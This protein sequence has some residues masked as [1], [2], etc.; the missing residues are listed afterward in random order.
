M[1]PATHAHLTAA[2]GATESVQV[3]EAMKLTFLSLPFDG[4]LSVK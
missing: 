3:P 2:L 4:K 1:T